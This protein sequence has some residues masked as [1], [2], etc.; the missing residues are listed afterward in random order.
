MR[1]RQKIIIPDYALCASLHTISP[2]NSNDIFLLGPVVC[3]RLVLVLVLVLIML[4]RPRAK[5]AKHSYCI[6]VGFRNDA[7]VDS[8]APH[9]RPL[10]PAPHREC[11]VTPGIRPERVTELYSVTTRP[12]CSCFSRGHTCIR[13][14]RVQARDWI[15][16]VTS[17]GCPC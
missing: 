14:G 8:F 11:Q 16:T 10:M 1:F 6:P 13:T 9:Y 4:Q 12:Y 7:I 3:I 5:R 2:P 15:N 17:Y